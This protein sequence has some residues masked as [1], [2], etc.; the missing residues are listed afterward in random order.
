M[1]R[2]ALTFVFCCSLV[3]LT[4]AESQDA[5]AVHHD[6]L[7]KS[8]VIIAPDHDT[9]SKTAEEQLAE[10]AASVSHAI[11]ELAAIE[12]ANA[13][14]PAVMAS[15]EPITDKM[16]EVASVDYQGP[17]EPLLRRIAKVSDLSFKTLGHNSQTDIMVSL[18]SRKVPITELL[19]D[20]SFQI[21]KQ[22]T[23]VLNPK[24]TSLELHY[25]PLTRS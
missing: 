3:G 12:R 6:P 11:Q 14:K 15:I 19:R 22:A 9:S 1:K 21:Q 10:A 17:V 7:L 13:E 23:L 5:K 4:H 18:Y 24:T 2:N 16:S 25:Q 20:I 8:V